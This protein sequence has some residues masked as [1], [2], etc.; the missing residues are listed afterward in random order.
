MTRH[1][2]DLKERASHAKV[3]EQLRL[4]ADQIARGRVEVAYD[5]FAQPTVV[6]DPIDLVFDLVQHK[7]DAELTIV[8]RWKTPAE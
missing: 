1:V 2:F 3:A 5:E 8:M 7:H 4:L 6:H